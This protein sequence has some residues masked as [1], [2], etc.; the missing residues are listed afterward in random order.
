M[1]LQFFLLFLLY[2]AVPQNAYNTFFQLEFPQ[3][4]IEEH[5]VKM[6]IYDIDQEVIVKWIN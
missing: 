6:L 4:M 2:L 1:L 3:E 5:R